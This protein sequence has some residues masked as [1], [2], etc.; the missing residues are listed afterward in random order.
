MLL[1]VF[2]LCIDSILKNY[3]AI[4]ITYYLKSRQVFGLFV[5]YN[6]AGE[7]YIGDVPDMV[8]RLVNNRSFLDSPFPLVAAFLEIER[9]H[10]FKHVNE[11]VN[12]SQ[13]K[14][15][16]DLDGGSSDSRS[17]EEG[18]K[19]RTVSHDF[20]FRLGTLRMQLIVWSAQLK[21]LLATCDDILDFEMESTEGILL[22]PHD[23]VT[24]VIEDC[25][26]HIL[27]C[28]SILQVMSLAFQKVLSP[29]NQMTKKT[30]LILDL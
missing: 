12:E 15:L 11:M 8:T 2:I 9:K 1:I 21:K 29:S 19:T 22:D 5:G 18:K 6:I 23:Y 30:L 24:E 7:G 17:L 25:E 27:R 20:N 3:T 26:Q 13:E 16:S 28:D 10:R 14:L 4:C